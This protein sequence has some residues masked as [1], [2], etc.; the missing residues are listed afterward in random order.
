LIYFEHTLLI[1]LSILLAITTYFIAKNRKSILNIEKELEDIFDRVIIMHFDLNGVILKVSDAYEGIFGFDKS[2]LIGV[3]IDKNYISPSKP[4]KPIWSFLEEEGH[5]NGE[6]QLFDNEGKPYWMHKQIIKKYHS[7]EEH[8]G[9]ISIAHDITAIKL[10]QEQQRRIVDQSRHA[11]MGEMISMIAHQWRQPLSTLTSITSHIRLDNE[12]GRVEKK[13]LNDKLIDADKIVMHLSTTLNEFRNFFKNNKT[14][15]R[16]R[17]YQLVKESLKLIDFKLKNIEIELL[18]DKNFSFETLKGEYI[19]VILNLISN[20]ADAL[21]DIENP[22]ITIEL[23]LTDETVML[24]V[25]DNANGIPSDIIDKI[26]DP[27]FSTKSKNGTGLGLYI[28]KTIL[29]EH[30]NGDIQVQSDKTGSC[31]NIISPR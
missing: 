28:C 18:I 3:T 5:F 20:A 13:E 7:N 25:C 2:D 9:F 6:M 29:Q 1:V 26:F 4:S 27:Y 31:F 12:L 10:Y 24:K 11:L 19:Q 23:E 21:K 14:I 17:L 16:T 8:T 15:E 22:K 30:L